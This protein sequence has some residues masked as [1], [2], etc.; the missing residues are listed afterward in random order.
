MSITGQSGTLRPQHYATVFAKRRSSFLRSAIFARIPSRCRA[1]I[2]LTSA[3]EV[4]PG[5]PDLIT[6]TYSPSAFFLAATLV[7]VGTAYWLVYRSSKLACGDGAACARPLPNKFVKV[8][9]RP[10]P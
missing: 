3:Q 6:P 8:A 10:S 5:H 7:C 9:Q 4:F 1:A 2:V